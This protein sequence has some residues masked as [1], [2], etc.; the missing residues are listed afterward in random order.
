MK[1]TKI[2]LRNKVFYQVFVRNHTVEGTF[3]SLEEDLDR[4][5]ELGVDYIYLLPVHPIGLKN[6]KGT[7]GSPYSISDYGLIN[8]LLGTLDDFIHL[9]QE[10]HARNLKVMMDIVYNHTSRDSKIL[11]EHPEWFYHNQE[12]IISNRVG[13]WW[14]IVDLDF[15]KDKRLW[16]ELTEHLVSYAKLGIDGFRCDVA[17]LVP[18]EFWHYARKKVHKVNKNV[19]W[20]SESVHGG[21]VKYLR[22]QGFKCAS[23]SEMYQEFDLAYDYDIHPFYEGYLLGKNSFQEYIRALDNQE[24]VYPQNYVKLHNLEN[25]DFD[26]IAKYVDNDINK[27]LNWN[28]FLFLQ[29]GAVLLYAG[30]EYASDIKPNLFEKDIMKKNED[31]QEFFKKLTYLKKKPIFASGVYKFLDSTV[32]EVA[33]VKVENQK[34]IIYGIFNIG[35]KEGSIELPLADKIYRN[36]LN[37]KNI[38][39]TN[40]QFTLRKEPVIIRMKK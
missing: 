34:E 36:Y 10:A 24:G 32:D 7:L 22:D 26:R 12:G 20:L 3:K 25:H 11:L 15:T 18:L 2:S 31:I 6:R 29:K 9:I 8:P 28:A 16:F 38:S 39:V 27:I 13:D 21:F 40:H 37:R 30:Q 35:Q 14:D 4:I 33:I 1:S 5:A 19:I 17:S 23:E